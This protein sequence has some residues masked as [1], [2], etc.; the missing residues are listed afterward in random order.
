MLSV[1]TCNNPLPTLFKVITVLR[2]YDV[3]SCDVTCFCKDRDAY[4]IDVYTTLALLA[5][6]QVFCL[7][8]FS[9]AGLCFTSRHVYLFV[10]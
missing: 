3:I 9:T 2:F 10:G 4:V 6:E 8:P 7:S 1:L 5:R